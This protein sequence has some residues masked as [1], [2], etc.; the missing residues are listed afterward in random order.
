[1]CFVILVSF[2]AGHFED[3]IGLYIV[4]YIRV[5]RRVVGRLT[6]LTTYVKVS[7]SSINLL[8]NQ[9]IYFILTYIVA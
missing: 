2:L 3:K 6:W 5:G 1:M 7:I 4:E 8:I 9:L